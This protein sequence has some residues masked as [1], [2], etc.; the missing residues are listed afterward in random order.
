MNDINK[1][2]D[3]NLGGVML[4]KFI[5]VDDV[6]EIP[7]AINNMIASAVV[8]KPATRWYEFYGT[9]G[10]IE[11]NE[12]QSDSE[13]GS[14]FKKSLKAITPK[15]RTDVDLIFGEMKNRRFILDV[16]DNN[17]IRKIVGTI[18]EGL[19]FTSKASTK[20]EATQRNEYV[21][22]FTGDGENKS[23]TYNL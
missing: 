23:P 11:F 16:L 3:D 22:E 9:I 19:K 7:T 2:T 20:G 14:Y 8:L 10:T 13:A 15:N 4:F 21:I 5:P 18:Q 17:G 12:D 1:F 6:Q